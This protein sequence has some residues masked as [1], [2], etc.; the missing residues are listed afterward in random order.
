MTMDV[1]RE[2]EG[3]T[4]YIPW[5][6]DYRGRAYPIPNLLTPQDTD[7]G[8]SLLL[9]SEGAK[10]TKKGMEWIKF[11]LATTYGLDKATMQERL[12][13]IDNAENYEMVQ[14]VWRDPIDNIADW[15]NADEPW[16]FLAACNEFCELHFEH[17]FHTHLPIAVDAT[18]SGLKS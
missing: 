16:L 15:E 13:L 3:T 17:R 4:F 12:E 6:F 2:F 7:F 14:R 11:Q 1:V 18:C 5:S 8:K 9:F 10:I